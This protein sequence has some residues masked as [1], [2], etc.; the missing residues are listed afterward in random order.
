[1]LPKRLQ[2]GD[3]V[4]LISPAGVAGEEWI[5]KTCRGL[6][7]LGLK[8][9]FA[10]SLFRTTWGYAASAQERAD[11]FQTMLCRADIQMILFGGGEVC[12]ELLPLMPYDLIRQNAKIICSYSDSTTLLNSIYAKTGLITY[13]GASPGTFHA[14]T[15]YNR[16]CFEE[17][18]FMGKARP[19]LEGGPW[20]TIWNGQAEGIL[21][22]GY[23]ENFALLTDGAYLPIS[24]DKHYLLF[25]EDHIRFHQPAAVARYLAHIEQSQF[26]RQ[27]T[28]L[29][30]GHYSEPQ[31]P[32][33]IALL[34]RFA[35]CHA[36]PTIFCDDF[37]HGDRNAI[38]PIGVPAFLDA[39]RQQLIFQ[40]DT[41]L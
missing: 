33:L 17:M 36:L 5:Q 12:H 34:Q 31:N 7:T 25:L 40:Q 21:I 32:D 11:D 20:K 10:P 24:P 28:G 41:V 2:T 14:L 16:K 22:G 3:T 23:L 4:G 13:Y 29:L 18:F 38:L 30:F 1:M 37:G 15:P 27:V 39:Q 26:F 8:T 35:A 6:E 19:F 9:E